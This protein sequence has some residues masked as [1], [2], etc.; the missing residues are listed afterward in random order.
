MRRRHFLGSIV[1]NVLEHYDN[2]LFGLLAPFIAPLF[3]P[4]SSPLSALIL[5][6]GM[7]AIGIF[8]K[9]IGALVFGYIGDR[10]GRKRVLAITLIG[11]AIVTTCIG[12]LPTYATVGPLAPVLLALGRLLQAFFSAGETTGGAL[13]LLEGSEEGKKSFLSSLYD[14]SSILG[15][16]MASLVVTIFCFGQDAFVH[17]WRVPFFLG[18]LCGI[19]GLLIRKWDEEE[20]Q[21]APSTIRSHFRAVWQY[22]KSVVPIVLVSGFSYAVYTFSVTLLNGFLPLVSD[23]SKQEASTLNTFLLLIDFLLLPF[24]GFVAAKWGKEKLMRA[25]SFIAIIVCVPLFMQLQSASIVTA[26]FVRLAFVTIGVAFAAAYHHWSQERVPPSVRF[27]VVAT[28]TALGAQLIGKPSVVISLWLY[29]KT[30]WVAAPGLYL[31]VTAAL[32]LGAVGF[33][34]TAAVQTET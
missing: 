34:K 16:F 6:Y 20:E 17:F 1:G 29:Q 8:S 26:L 5:T 4:N 13:Y 25:S 15:I 3:F 9:P 2:A 14:C 18:S 28:A 23:I 21:R 32:A 22:R 10:Y 12:C 19:M 11:M 30:G 33:R 31:M 7:L 27:T 24:F